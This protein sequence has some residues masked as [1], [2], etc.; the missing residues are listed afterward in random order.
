M[1]QV[2]TLKKYPRKVEAGH[3]WLYVS[4]YPSS[5]KKNNS[6]VYEWHGGTLKKYPGKVEVKDGIMPLMYYSWGY[7]NA[8]HQNVG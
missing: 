6:T 2:G 1:W 3:P 5:E 8:C 4:P 7:A